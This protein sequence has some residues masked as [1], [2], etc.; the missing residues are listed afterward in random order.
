MALLEVTEQLGSEGVP[1]SEYMS[2][3]LRASAALASGEAATVD[4]AVPSA[5]VDL[6]SEPMT[7]AESVGTLLLA[8]LAAKARDDEVADEDLLRV[9]ALAAVLAARFETYLAERAS[10]YVS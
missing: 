5:V 3:M 8:T 4:D 6:L 1:F 9:M 10:A 2:E 7:A